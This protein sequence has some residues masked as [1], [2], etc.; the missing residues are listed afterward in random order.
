MKQVRESKVQ[1]DIIKYLRSR[2]FY[3]YKNAAGVYTEPG[4]PD[5]TACIYGHFVGIEIKRPG[6]L[7]NVSEAQKIV[8]GQIEKAC[9]IWIAVDD[10]KEVENLVK[11][12]EGVT[13]NDAILGISEE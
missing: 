8:G 7:D 10:V 13:M 11:R 1:S 2:G 9:G 5:L 4:R 6:K 3:V 12:I